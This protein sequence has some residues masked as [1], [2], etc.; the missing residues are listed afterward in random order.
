MNLPNLFNQS[1][2]SVYKTCKSW[3]D[4]I[5]QKIICMHQRTIWAI[6]SKGFYPEL[7]FLFS[8]GRFLCVHVRR[9]SSSR[10]VGGTRQTFI[11]SASLR[12]T[13][14]LFSG[15][16]PSVWIIKIWL[17]D[18]TVSSWGYKVL[19]SWGWT[20]TTV[21]AAVAVVPPDLIGC[22]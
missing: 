1:F 16:F 8:A 22:S 17:D 21:V 19:L 20:V 2:D 4:S 15:F 7:F 14:P 11:T 10:C 5:I 6:V 18:Q 9:D 3:A 13:L 12:G